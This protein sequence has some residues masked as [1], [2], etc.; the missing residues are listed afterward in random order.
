MQERHRDKNLYFKEQGITTE[1]YIIPLIEKHLKIGGE[2]RVLEIGCG[3]GGNLLPFAERGC[4]CLGIDTNEVKIRLG[5]DFLS[6]Y[7]M[8]GKIELIAKF[9]AS[10]EPQTIGTFDLIVL[11]DFIEHVE[12]QSKFM[13]EI[14]SLLKKGGKIFYA[15]PLWHMPF[16]GHQ[17]VCNS[18]L[19]SKWPWIHLLPNFLYRWILKA[20][21]EP[22][23]K[24][25]ELLILH[26]T[27]LTIGKFRKILRSNR[28]KIDFEIFYLI[29]PNY[30]TKFKL[31]PRR[32]FSW[33][34]A[35]PGIRNFFTTCCYYL[36]GK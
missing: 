7:E 23:N 25:R 20:F 28:W 9:F 19:L 15:F 31:K 34:A 36:V 21:A 24:I 22:E 11:K 6:E 32:Q 33:L 35:I 17:Q 8:P 4:D 16:G 14:D 30:E 18:R 12:D 5:L 3:E 1:K 27:G 26:K 29:N 13:S 10:P 2:T